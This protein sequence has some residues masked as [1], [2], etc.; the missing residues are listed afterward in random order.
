MIKKVWQ[1]LFRLLKS[2]AFI[3][4]GIVGFIVSAFVSSVFEL[5]N[6]WIFYV[7]VLPIGFIIGGIKLFLEMDLEIQELKSEI[8]HYKLSK[9]KFE[10]KAKVNDREVDDPCLLLHKKPEYPDIE[11]LV[12]EE[13]KRLLSKRSADS[14]S[15]FGL[16]ILKNQPN[17]NFQREL[18]V[19]LEDYKRYLLQVW[20]CSINRSNEINLLIRNQGG[21]P[22]TDITLDLLMPPQY[23]IP[24]EHHQYNRET[25]LRDQI[26]SH[27]NKPF[28]P[29]PFIDFN[30]WSIPIDLAPIPSNLPPYKDDNPEYKQKDDGIHVIYKIDK[31][32]QHSPVEDLEP[33]WIWLGNIEE[34]EP[35]NI[36]LKITCA[37]LQQPVYEN[38]SIKIRKE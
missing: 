9:P 7:L 27:V 35:W 28:A 18:E 33:F 22:A 29:K 23:S 32:I 6:Q 20:E 2:T 30:T 31:L 25:T 26:I 13:K 15:P 10:I 24:K 4:T 38:I 34:E 14:S 36:K 21:Q 19:Y 11:K 1:Y 37:E 8:A 3:V 16:S 12:S 5:E 17:K